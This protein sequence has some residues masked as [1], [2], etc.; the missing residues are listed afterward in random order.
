MEKSCR[1]SGAIQVP[2]ECHSGAI[3]VPFKVLMAINHALPGNGT[4]LTRAR[5]FSPSD[6][7]GLCRI[8][9]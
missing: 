2:I 3:Q 1:P 6:T 4:Q 9:Q 8:G 7:R 5:A